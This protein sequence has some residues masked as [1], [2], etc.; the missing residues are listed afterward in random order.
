MS[1]LL[2]EGPFAST[3]SLNPSPRPNLKMSTTQAPL[4][5]VPLKSTSDV[6]YAQSIRQTI[7]QT[8]QESP[9]TYKEEILSLDRCRQDALRGSAG[10]DVTGSSRTDS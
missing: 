6:S 3:L 5:W 2:P 8:Y 1:T 9:D 4:L 10:S 7:T